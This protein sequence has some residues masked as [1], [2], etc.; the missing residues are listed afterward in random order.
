MFYAIHFQTFG[1]FWENVYE[2]LT[3]CSLH[4]NGHTHDQT[5]CILTWISQV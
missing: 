5:V 3:E 2:W 1:H 4:T